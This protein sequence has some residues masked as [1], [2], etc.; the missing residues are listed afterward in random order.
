[1]IP[2]NITEMLHKMCQETLSNADVNAICKARGF[3]ARESATRA[4]FENFFLSET[5][6]A[7]AMATLDRQEV[8]LLHLLHHLDKAV[9]VTVLGPIYSPKTSSTYG[10]FTQRYRDVFTAARTNL[11]RRGL[12]LMAEAPSGGDTQMERWRFR[13]PPQFERFL[14]PLFEKLHT[15]AG[16]GEVNTQIVRATVMGLAQK[17]GEPTLCADDDFALRLVEGELRLGKRPFRAA[18]LAEWQSAC[19]AEELDKAG[20]P[21][22]S[23]SP[24]FVR[25]DIAIKDVTPVDAALLYILS[26]LGPGQWIGPAQLEPILKI[27]AQR[28]T[29]SAAQICETGW[30]WGCLARHVDGDAVYYRL[31]AQE[32]VA[33]AGLDRS[34]HLVGDDVIVDLRT[35]AYADLESLAQVARL[36]LDKGN[37]HAEPDL[38]RLGRAWPALRQHP[39]REWLCTQAPAFRKGFKQVEAR[40]GKRIVHENLMV[41][42][43]NNLSLKVALERAFAGNPEIL[44]LSDDTLAFPAAWRAEVERAVQ[45]AGHVVKTISNDV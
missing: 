32:Q 17:T 34:L 28:S 44:F 13:F 2:M 19:W 42:R 38:I 6:V 14:P 9:D 36:R 4:L 7:A 33:G 45:K 22:K 41:A 40:W 39:L 37:L 43:V 30:R 15:W 24:L 3:S 10:T 26:R 29:L 18:Y 1:M 16:D 21:A 31:P 23:N 12:L 25:F 11:V 8:I 35:V 5:G 20:K 27:F